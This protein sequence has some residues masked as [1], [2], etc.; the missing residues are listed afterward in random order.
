[1][2]KKSNWEMWWL[3]HDLD[4]LDL[5]QNTFNVDEGLN[6]ELYK[7]ENIKLSVVN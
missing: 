2:N 3:Y 4:L 1:M 7:Q 6:S 5:D